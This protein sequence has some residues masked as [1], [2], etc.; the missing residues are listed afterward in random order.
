MVI[1]SEFVDAAGI[2]PGDALL[3]SQLPSLC[4][5]QLPSRLPSQLP[6]RQPS[7]Q[8]GPP[9]PPQPPPPCVQDDGARAA[10]EW[11]AWTQPQRI[12]AQWQQIMHAQWCQLAAMQQAAD[13]ERAWVAAAQ[14]VQNQMAPV[15]ARELPPPPTMPPPPMPPPP[16][17]PMPPPPPQLPRRRQ[18]APWR[19]GGRGRPPLAP[20]QLKTKEEKRDVKA[21]RDRKRRV[22]KAAAAAAAAAAFA[23]AAAAAAASSS[24]AAQE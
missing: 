10:A 19:P 24:A 12:S 13:S 5:S 15:V 7:P 21:K 17:Q 1:L 9:Q 11:A 2:E 4:P 23:A 14:A 8:R 22:E 3:P 20:D 18:W 6:S 16:T